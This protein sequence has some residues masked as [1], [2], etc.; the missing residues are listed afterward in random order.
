MVGKS[1]AVHKRIGSNELS[2]VRENDRNRIGLFYYYYR[3]NLIGFW[4]YETTLY[5][6]LCMG[7][8]GFDFLMVLLKGK[9][10]LKKMGVIIRAFFAFVF[11][12][13]GRESFKNRALI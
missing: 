9:Y 3:N 4:E 10:K 5:K 11:G 7:K 2:I 8:L 13:Y 1:L 6:L 12:T